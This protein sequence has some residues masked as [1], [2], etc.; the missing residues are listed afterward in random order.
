[1]DTYRVLHDP[2]RTCAAQAFLP[3][4]LDAGQPSID[5]KHPTVDGLQARDQTLFFPHSAILELFKPKNDSNPVK[6]I[7]ECRCKRC[8]KGPGG[9]NL[10][11]QGPLAVK[12]V[13]RPLIVLLAI[14][15]FIGHTHLIGL[16]ASH[17]RIDDSSLDSV[18]QYIRSE[19]NHGKW[20]KLL[21]LHGVEGFCKFYNSARNLFQ[22][23]TF[24]MGKPTA[25]YLRT[26]RMPFLD[27]QLHERGSSGKVYKFNIHSDYLD[28][29]IKHEDWYSS[30]NPVSIRL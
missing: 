13:E 7:L 4:I 15:I 20:Q 19:E 6:S 23:P 10:V 3:K 11:E 2:S 9:R 22:L 27:D 24:S 14:L 17:D 28:E 5:L 25:L 21:A 29:E 18:T 8:R 1:M 26:Q 16:F 12:I 30:K